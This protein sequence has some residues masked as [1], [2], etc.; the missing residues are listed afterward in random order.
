MTRSELLDEILLRWDEL[1]EQGSAPTAEDLCRDQPE[2]AGEVARRIEALQAVY[3]V[4]NTAT[5]DFPPAETTDGRGVPRLEDYEILEM[6]GSGGMG[7]VFKAR[8]KSL[9]RLVALKVIHSG[10]NASPQEAE[11][12]RI[13]AEAVAGLQHPNIVQIH[14]VGRQDG[15]PFLALEYVPG[16]SLEQRLRGGP[17]PPRQAAELV[18]TLAL[19]MQHAHER[20][21]VHRDL[22]PANILF[23]EAG[24]PR[25][26]DFGLARKLDEAGQMTRTGTVLGTPS[27]MAP[28]QAEGRPSRVGPATDVYALG[29]I[30]YECLTGRPPFQGQTLLETL[31]MVRT[32]APTLPRR[33]HPQVPIDLETICLKCLEK[34]PAARYPGAHELADDLGRFLDDEPIRVRPPGLVDQLKHTLNRTRGLPELKRS[35]RIVPPLVLGLVLIQAV[36]CLGSYGTPAYPMVSLLTV[37]LTVP[38]IMAL[39]LLYT[40]EGWRVP[41]TTATRHFWSVR[42]GVVLGLYAVPLIGWRM[43]PGGDWDPLTVFPFWAI[44]IGVSMFGLGVYWGRLYL[45]GL[46]WLLLAILLPLRLDLAPFAVVGM[47]GLTVWAVF[48]QITRQIRERD[49]KG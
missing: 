5:I 29:A 49:E 28:E 47:F 13:E 14:E 39:H 1:R 32:E 30:L 3:R 23:D 46:F 33:V 38:G 7:K 21:I 41:L 6:L 26:A 25:I 27:Y 42:V 2:L 37:L 24:A 8:Q 43:H 17:L 44:L 18:R 40:G 19:A 10:S 22:K 45:I 20:G 16:G 36:A 31:E 48:R 34:E 12:F 4:P 35:I 11:R 15:C 9:K